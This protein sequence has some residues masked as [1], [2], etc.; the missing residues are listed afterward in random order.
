MQRFLEI[1]LTNA[2]LATAL[3]V[4]AVL[5]S[6]VCK[7]PAVS[8]T[9]WL[10]VLLKLLSPPF[11]T[12]PVSWPVDLEP[13]SGGAAQP[14]DEDGVADRSADLLADRSDTP[15]E[16]RD[17]Y[18]EAALPDSVLP[19]VSTVAQLD[20]PSGDKAAEAPQQAPASP[21]TSPTVSAT[22]VGW[23][24]LSCSAVW[25][26]IA[27][28]RI[29]RF[30]RLLDYGGPAS[31]FLQAQARLLAERMGMARC[32]LVWMVP[33]RISPLLW[34]VGGRVRLVLPAGL[35]E[36]LN[37]EQQAALLAHELAHARRHDHWVRW[38]ELIATSLYWWHPVAW[39]AR[40][41]I[42]QAEE[43]CCD[44]W[45]VWLLPAAAKA[46]AK[47]LLQTVNY[48]DAQPALPPVA[49]GAGHI[50]FLR[51]R[52][53]MIVR[54]P[55]SPRQPWALHLGVLVLGLA[56]LPIAPQH[57]EAQAP[58]LAL[59]NLLVDEPERP[60]AK[61]AA[62]QSDIE[63]RMRELEARMDRVLRALE[64][65]G[66]GEEDERSQARDA[67]AKAREMAARVRER[68]AREAAR[69][70]EMA[71]KERDE[72]REKAAKERD[73]ARE[74]AAKEKDKAA[75]AKEK[76]DPARE[77]KRFAQFEGKFDPEKLKRLE[78]EIN[79][80]VK[81]AVNPER[82][83]QL[84]KQINEAVSKSINPERMKQLEKQI[85]EAVN[86]SINP[87]RMEALARQIE[88]AIKRSFAAEERERARQAE[89]AR[90]PES[91]DRD[92][93]AP[94]RGASG[95]SSGDR[96]D[97]ER[98]LERLEQKMERVLE[99]MESSSKSKR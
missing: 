41:E 51:R 43:Q 13:S 34:A 30:H 79:A 56:V 5:V 73:A 42:Q 98:R 27:G 32:P 86:R 63:R 1:S 47:A 49:S 52:L 40:H 85:D 28:I 78:K 15:G 17:E 31:A 84:E 48:L 71:A 8:H 16:Q 37:R 55:M 68:A 91:P 77:F 12:I 18:E 76:A 92:G 44:A 97:L 53:T 93:A 65:R 58:A 35:V 99:A 83:K 57:V 4:V 7:R 87:Q 82:M 38:L 23:I 54:E 9:L 46:Y 96:R 60:K 45:V 69:A 2:V 10:L 50:H 90:P 21:S 6:R 89:R 81:E 20:F 74:K 19:G 62:P 14:S 94:R 26:T 66:R 67:A 72:A 25:F 95:S 24:W 70:R 36:D 39:W 3:A 64:A 29:Y 80:A 11:V 61:P 22:W 88:S 33:G 59:G 75:K